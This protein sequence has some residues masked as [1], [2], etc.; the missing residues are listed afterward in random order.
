MVIYTIRVEGQIGED[1]HDWFDGLAIINHPGGQATL[2]GPV[3][4]QAALHGLLG[5]LR[6]LNLDLVEIKRSRTSP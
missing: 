5:R 4:D 3:V 2:E 1:W 6:D